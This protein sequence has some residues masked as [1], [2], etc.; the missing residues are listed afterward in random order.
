MGLS[1]LQTVK[2][3]LDVPFPENVI[4]TILSTVG[5]IGAPHLNFLGVK[6][7][8]KAV[9]PFGTSLLIDVE[10]LSPLFQLHL[11]RYFTLKNVDITG[12]KAFDFR[13]MVEAWPEIQCSANRVVR[14]R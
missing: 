3:R 14:G 7:G 9:L 6:L 8:V 4:T 2:L 5:I 12:V 10:D 1:Q 13:N 11:L